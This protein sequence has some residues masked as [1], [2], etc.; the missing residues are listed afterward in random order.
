MQVLNVQIIYYLLF[1]AFLCFAFPD[2]LKNTKM[3]KAFLSGCSLFW[4]IRTV[5][6]FIFYETD[7]F[8]TVLSVVIMFGAG[9]VLFAL[10]VFR[11]T[12]KKMIA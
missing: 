4:L 5:Q 3:G 11:K 10:P 9:A 1:V 8:L 6:Q 2:E 7:G 12:P